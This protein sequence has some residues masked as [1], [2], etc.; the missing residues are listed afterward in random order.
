VIGATTAFQAA[1]DTVDASG[2]RVN[3]GVVRLAR[4]LGEAAVGIGS[5][6]AVLEEGRARL[7]AVGL[8]GCNWEQAFRAASGADTAAEPTSR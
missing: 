6:D 5:A 4:G 1:Q 2:D 7:A 8:D 3:Q